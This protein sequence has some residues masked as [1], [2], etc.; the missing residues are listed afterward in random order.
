VRQTAFRADMVERAFVDSN[1]AIVQRT[2]PG[3]FFEF[4]QRERLHDPITGATRLDLAFDSRNAQ[5][6]FKMTAAA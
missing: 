1:G 6:I 3:S 5:G 2:V 4:I